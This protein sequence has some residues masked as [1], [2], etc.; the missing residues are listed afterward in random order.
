MK[1]VTLWLPKTLLDTFD[2]IVNME[3]FHSRNHLIIDLMRQ[4]IF[5]RNPSMISRKDEKE[6][7]TPALRQI[8][9]PLND[10]L[11]EKIDAI[12]IKESYPDRSALFIEVLSQAIEEM[13]YT[14]E[15]SESK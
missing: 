2:M 9:L 1:L 4:S 14:K 8:Y 6:E 3:L 7:C 13:G 15:L 11:L 12:V 5:H 10:M